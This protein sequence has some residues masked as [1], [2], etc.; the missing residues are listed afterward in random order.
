MKNI[1]KKILN[2]KKKKKVVKKKIKTVKKA[3]KTKNINK[4]LPVNAID[5]HQSSIGYIYKKLNNI[6]KI[7]KDEKPYSVHRLD[8]ETSGVFLIAKN[9]YVRISDSE[10]PNFIKS[11]LFIQLFEKLLK[12]YCVFRNS[13][14]I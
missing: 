7:F 14:K 4:P 9:K 2:S 12:Q 8:K 10:L 1:L 5:S 11:I 6:L 3:V 13:I